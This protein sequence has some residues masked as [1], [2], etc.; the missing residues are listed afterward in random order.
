MSDL[1]LSSYENHTKL[2]VLRIAE[3]AEDEF[4]AQLNII[5]PA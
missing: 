1:L 4:I 5:Y 2:M 3:Q